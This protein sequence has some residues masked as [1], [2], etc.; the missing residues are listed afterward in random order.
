MQQFYCQFHSSLKS[1]GLSEK[2]RALVKQLYIPVFRSITVNIICGEFRGP[3]SDAL[4]RFHSFTGRKLATVYI[5]GQE[6]LRY[7]L[8]V[9]HS[10]HCCS[11]AEIEFTGHLA[12]PKLPMN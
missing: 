3:S 6:A 5:L 9:V 12:L 10:N 8:G 7:S 1:V 2:N 4:R 11:R